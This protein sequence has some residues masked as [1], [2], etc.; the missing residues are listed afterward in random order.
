MAGIYR[1]LADTIERRP[2]SVFEGRLSL[3][4]SEKLGVAAR[5]LIRAAGSP[6]APAVRGAA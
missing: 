1:R 2:A 6:P 3:S 5:A 4:T